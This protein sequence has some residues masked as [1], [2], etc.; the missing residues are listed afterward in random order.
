[1]PARTTRT[2]VASP[3]P[4]Q[5]GYGL[6]MER[7]LPSGLVVGGQPDESALQA[8]KS[9]GRELV[10]SL[11]ATEEADQD[12]EPK[13]VA[14]LGMSFVSL[15]VKGS[16]GVTEEAARSLDEVLSR[17]PAAKT[18]L[19]CAAGNR[20]GALLALRGFFVADLTRTEALS[21]GKDAGLA[22]LTG[23]VHEVISEACAKTPRRVAAGQ[24]Q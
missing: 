9:A 1:M 2:V 23:R 19:H 20:A 6:P 18:L 14:N 16:A 7:H 12:Q 21:L 15:P 4:R 22:G 3:A 24:C 17:A 13:W 10:V 8:A 5:G 11:R